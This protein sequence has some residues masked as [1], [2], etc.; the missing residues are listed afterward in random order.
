MPDNTEHRM[1]EL[2][3]QVAVITGAASGIGYAAAQ[4]FAEEGARLLLA[5]RDTEAGETLAAELRDAGHEAIFQTTDVARAE[6]CAAMVARA[7]D[8]YGRLDCAFNN[9]GISDGPQ[10]PGFLDYSAELWQRML[11]VNLGGVFH[12]LQ[13][14]L[15]A[16]LDSGGGAIVNTA[17]I[18]GQIAFPGVPGY[19][20]SKHGVVGLTRTV[21]VEFGA[22]AIRCNAIAPGFVTTPMTEMVFGAPQGQ[23]MI[24]AAV[25]MQRT[26]TAAEIAELALWLCTSRAGYVNGG[27]Y[28][29]DG[30]FLAR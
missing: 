22:R 8:H 29:A 24:N 20:A 7:L 30:G 9:A 3:N 5:D 27:V 14:E 28:S 4:R 2:S 12:C 21:A 15:R 6:D 1:H 16:M 25:P 10:P 18:A 26:G 23:E 17:S 19:V 11:A 13:H